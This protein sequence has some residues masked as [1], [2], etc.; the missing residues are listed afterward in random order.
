[1]S[2]TL[3]LARTTSS[4]WYGYCFAVLLRWAGWWKMPLVVRITA[5]AEFLSS[6]EQSEVAT[7]ECAL[8]VSIYPAS[9]HHPVVVTAV[10]EVKR[11]ETEW[12]FLCAID[13]LFGLAEVGLKKA[14]QHLPAAGVLWSISQQT[15]L[16]LGLVHCVESFVFSV[17]L[18]SKS[19]R[20]GKQYLSLRLEMVLWDPKKQRG[21]Q[22]DFLRL[23]MLPSGLVI[24]IVMLM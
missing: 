13:A 21:S 4:T 16:L 10:D 22:R 24:H 19:L 18:M 3:A 11:S 8:W 2:G 6:L 5:D 23:M 15:I 17:S 14:C 20:S 12:Q 9:R 7:A 1:M